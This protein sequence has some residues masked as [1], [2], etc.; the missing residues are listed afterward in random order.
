MKCEDCG[1]ETGS[2]RKPK[3]LDCWKK[4]MD[5]AREKAHAERA[6]LEGSDEQ[7]KLPVAKPLAI[8]FGFQCACGF[9][10]QLTS[11]EVV[12]HVQKHAEA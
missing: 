4:G 3:C 2:D 7:L 12:N 10:G 9:I 8:E 5:A 6:Y 1:A 11:E